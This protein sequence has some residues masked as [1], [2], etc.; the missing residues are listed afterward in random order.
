[1]T[2]RLAPVLVGFALALAVGVGCSS[3]NPTPPDP[4]ITD[5]DPAVDPLL[6]NHDA[7]APDASD[8]AADAP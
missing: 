5:P 3:L 4:H 6:A 2:D 1:M 7:S 8:A